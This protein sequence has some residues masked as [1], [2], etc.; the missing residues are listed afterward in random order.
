M[1]TRRG[2]RVVPM[3]VVLPLKPLR[4]PGVVSFL[5]VKEEAPMTGRE[6][7][8]GLQLLVIHTPHDTKAAAVGRSGKVA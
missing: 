8:L 5:C 2:C 6:L 7:E 4:L 3:R 1:V